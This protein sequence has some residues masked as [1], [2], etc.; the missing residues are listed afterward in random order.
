V[1]AVPS[2]GGEF[3]AKVTVKNIGSMPASNV[4]VS[5]WANRAAVATNRFDLNLDGK[6]PL[7]ATVGTIATNASLIY[8]FTGLDAGTGKVARVCRVFADS[9]LALDEILETN[10]QLVKGYT[11]A[12]R[13][14]YVI[15]DI[16]LSTTN[17]PVG[18]NFTVNVTVKNIGYISGS[19]GY[20]DV[21]ANK[22]TNVVA[23]LTL[24]ELKKRYNDCSVRRL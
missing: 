15:T 11:P 7:S 12:S 2:R 6:P 10:N 19:A 13:P 23:G 16:T 20:M 18:S 8:T 1:P 22:A 17:P 21:W 5:V 14:D 24:R 4:L 3:D 9:D